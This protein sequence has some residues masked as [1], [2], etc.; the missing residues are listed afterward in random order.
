MKDTMKDTDEPVEEEEAV[1]EELE[2]LEPTEADLD[3]AVVPAEP[4]EP[5][6]PA[7][8]AVA[9]VESI[10]D[11]LVKQEARAEEE[12]ADE[13]EDVAVRAHQGRAPRARRDPGRSHPGH[14]V[15]LQ[16]VFPRQAPESAGRQEE[17][18]LPGLRLRARP[19]L[20]VSLPIAL[21]SGLLVSAASP[22]LGWWPLAFVGVA[23]FLWLLRSAGGA[24]GAL[25]GF[26][27][28]VG[29]YGATF[30]WI[31]RFGEM[32]WV[33]ITLLCAGSALVFGL[34]APAVQRHGRPLLTAVGLASLWTVTDWVRTAW[35][36]GGFSW[37]SLGVS[38]V[39]DRAVLHLATIT[40]VWG[41]TFVV[42][43]VNA[44]LVEAAVGGGG[45]GRR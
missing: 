45:A 2:D 23:P 37:G 24:R 16:E 8:P 10:Q 22:P 36:L 27:F 42:L 1:E 12:E 18:A 39:D 4:P 34:F 3:E 13:E 38:Q 21:A 35:P 19:S 20:L 14:R 40:G 41:V 6:D 44:L 28:G 43:A 7:D 9:E 33:A 11:L 30:Y 17:D 26:V 5:V 15:R 32:A 25:L 29:S 31:G